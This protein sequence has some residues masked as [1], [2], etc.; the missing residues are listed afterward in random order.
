MYCE[1]KILLPHAR[2]ISKLDP[3]CRRSVYLDEV[4]AGGNKY[5][6]E[7][8]TPINRSVLAVN[9]YG[10]IDMAPLTFKKRVPSIERITWPGASFGGTVCI[11]PFVFHVLSVM[12]CFSSRSDNDADFHCYPIMS[13]KFEVIAGLILW[14]YI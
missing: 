13:R 2:L 7:F 3:E 14:W 4:A 1:F 6:T 9:A 10:G 5:F 11:Q 12:V 8:D